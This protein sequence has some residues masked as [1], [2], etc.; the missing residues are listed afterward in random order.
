MT[1]PTPYYIG[2]ILIILVS[3]FGKIMSQKFQNEAPPS[4]IFRDEVLYSS[5]LKSM[6]EF[7]KIIEILRDSPW[8]CVSAAKVIKYPA[9]DEK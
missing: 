9:T 5:V 1:A 7:K 3:N 2:T 6:E 4:P 8:V